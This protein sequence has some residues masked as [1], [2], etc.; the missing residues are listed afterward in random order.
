MPGI[1]DQIANLLDC[2]DRQFV[3]WPATFSDCKNAGDDKYSD[4]HHSSGRGGGPCK[5]CITED[6]LALGVDRGYLEQ[7]KINARNNCAIYTSM[8]KKAG[9]KN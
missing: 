2:L 5:N 9:E 6:L 7:F 3:R 4:V 8:V 1:P